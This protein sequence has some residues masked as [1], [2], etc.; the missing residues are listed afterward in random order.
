MLS[1]LAEEIRRARP[2]DMRPPASNN[3]PRTTLQGRGPERIFLRVPR[4]GM[5]GKTLERAEK[6]WWDQRERCG[7]RSGETRERLD[8][9]ELQLRVWDEVTAGEK[10][11][12]VAR[13]FRMPIS[14]VRSA[15]LSAC[16][17]IGVAAV[18]TD[19]ACLPPVDPGPVAECSDVRC[20]S[21]KA[22]AEFCPRHK[23]WAQQDY[24]GQHD[25]IPRDLSAIEHAKARKGRIAAAEI[26]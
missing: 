15:Y 1:C 12:E 2:K 11:P 20:R 22:P 26:D 8:K 16:R 7:I 3:P 24:V 10:F 9:W 25:S 17:H 5:M 18:P 14:T 13:Q 4:W 19:K 6:I 21:A 23:A